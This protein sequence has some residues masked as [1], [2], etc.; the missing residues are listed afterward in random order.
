MKNINIKQRKSF[1]IIVV[2]VAAMLLSCHNKEVEE[3]VRAPKRECPFDNPLDSIVQFTK[4]HLRGEESIKFLTSHPDFVNNSKNIGYYTE[5][6]CDENSELLWADCGKVRVYSIPMVAVHHTYNY[7]F[8]QYK[9]A[10]STLDTLSIKDIIGGM[11]DLTMVRGKDGKSYYLLTT[12]LGYCHQGTSGFNETIYA[13]SISK[14]RFVKED[15]FH[16]PTGRYDHIEVECDGCYPL[17]YD[18]LSLIMSHTDRETSETTIVLALIN[19]NGWPT[20]NGLVY[21]WDGYCFQYVGKCKYNAAG[22]Y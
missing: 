15:I 12:T 22:Y 11:K 16:S 2:Q 21:E 18:S 7:N 10:A 19:E 5:G 14:G 13:F 9:D 1:F 3:S 20:G 6:G 4:I 8:I 17:D